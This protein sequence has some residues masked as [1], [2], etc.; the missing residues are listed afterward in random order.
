MKLIRWLEIPKPDGSKRRRSE[1]A[2]AIGV[3]PTMVTEYCKGAVWPSR[4]R[5]QAMYR[6]TGGMVTPND[7]VT[8]TL[9]PEARAEQPEAAE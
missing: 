1:F 3:T 6:E 8:L 2:T 7:F 9:A 5:M 4:E